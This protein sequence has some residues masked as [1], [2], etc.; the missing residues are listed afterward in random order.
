M[1]KIFVSGTELYN[2]E[3]Q[4]FTTI[5]DCTL[6]LEHSLVS[7]SKWESKFL[8][9]FLGPNEKTTEETLGYVEAMILNESYPE[10]VIDRLTQNDFAKINDYIA[11]NYSAT[12]FSNNNQRKGRGQ[13]EIITSE[14]IYYWLVAFNI[15]FECETWHLNR[16][17]SLIQICNIKNSKPKKM[18]RNEIAARNHALNEQRKAQLKTKG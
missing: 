12:T 6:T 8:K 15:P 4:E 7:L 3:T 10:D 5:E 13:S 18:S 17:F 14:L 2:E 11:S 9:P 1:L 16:L